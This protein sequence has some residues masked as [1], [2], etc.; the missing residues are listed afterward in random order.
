MI[1]QALLLKGVF[2]SNNQFKEVMMIVTDD[3]KAHKKHLKLA[4][5]VDIA[6]ITVKVL[7]RC[8]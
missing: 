4:E 5:I 7:K 6:V 2:L 1:R 3:I 8:A